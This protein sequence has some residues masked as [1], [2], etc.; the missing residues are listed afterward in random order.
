MAKKENSKKNI[1]EPIKK[2]I[3]ETFS[4]MVID[5]IEER[6]SEMISDVSFK[7]KKH[8]D[9][10]TKRALRN[11]MYGLVM[12]I[13]VLFLTLGI[14]YTFLDVLEVPRHLLFLAMGAITALISVIIMMKK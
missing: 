1:F 3:K 13:T 5:S 14:I 6:I 7:V 4:S 9:M 2:I 8:I 12:L 10:I 11:I